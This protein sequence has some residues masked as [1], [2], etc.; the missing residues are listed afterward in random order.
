MHD[1]GGILAT[2]LKAS[3]VVVITG[4]LGAGK[5]TLVK[6]IAETLEVTGV[7]TSPTFVISRKHKS[8]AKGIGLVHVDAY[9]LSES[10]DLR[11]LDLDELA[12]DV[13]VIEWGAPFVETLHCDWLELFISRDEDGEPLNIGQEKTWSEDDDPASGVRAISVIGHG[14]RW[15][16]VVPKIEN[17]LAKLLAVNE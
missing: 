16:D 7:V 17:E 12:A 2:F 5:T 14:T 15:H 3:D 10:S 1:V 4:P 9:R 6:G 8:G 11:D 13:A